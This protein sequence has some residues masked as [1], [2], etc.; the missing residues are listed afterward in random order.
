MLNLSLNEKEKEYVRKF[1]YKG[2]DTSYVYATILSP[3]AKLCVDE[4]IPVWMAPNVITL[5]G[6][7]ASVFSC[8]LTL[9]INPDLGPNA[10]SWL[11]LIAG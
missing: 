3:L 1:V 5:M 11:H 4:F 9:I 8:V 6:L 2:G 10:P 7:F